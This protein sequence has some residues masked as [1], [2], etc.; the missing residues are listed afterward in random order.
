MA[1]RLKNGMPL[2][3]L[4][5][6]FCGIAFYGLNFGSQ[7]DEA[8]GK[9]DSIKNTV[10]TGIFLQGADPTG[11]DYS[12]GGVNYL[13]TW[14]G[15]TPEVVRW[16][17]KGNLSREG[18]FAEIM[19]VLYTI[20][21]R[22][23]VRAIYVILSSL[24][25]VWIF[26]L[27]VSLG[28]TRGEAF[29]AAA[30]LAGSWEIG[31]HSRFVAPDVVMM[32]FGLLAFLCLTRAFNSQGR[33]W[34]YLGAATIGLA[35]GTKYTGGLVLPFFLA[36]AAY[37]TWRNERSLRKVALHTVGVI[38]VSALIFLV[39]T[40][41]ALIDPFRFFGQ[42]KEQKE[43][44]ASGWY[45]Y[46]VKPGF[47][48]FWEIVKYFA[49]QM[50]SHYWSVSL[51]LAAF[52]LLGF[53]FLLW[54][55]TWIGFLL[56][57]FPL[58][59]MGYFSMQAAMIVR[60][61]LIVAP[62]LCIAAARGIVAVG[63]RLKSLPQRILYAGIALLLII[64]FGWQIYA[65][66]QV[67]KRLNPEYFL[68]QFIAYAQE[69]QSQNILA[70]PN[71][72]NVLQGRTELPPNILTDPAGRYDKVA[73]F[74][75]EGADA[76]WRDWPSNSWGLYEKTFG[77]LEVN[78]EAYSTFMGNQRILLVTAENFRKLPLAQVPTRNE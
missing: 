67:K 56:V 70:S 35:A 72:A 62:F 9:F 27:C 8:R 49:I 7:W 18:L 25:I 26:C 46:T 13:L 28:R 51:I 30:M 37:A 59:Y 76:F 71:L 78:L 33:L 77:P 10:A 29:L 4:L 1:N 15:L 75:S 17:R 23:R 57:A 58:A 19:P 69:T 31:Y 20:P 44:Y 55:F 50:L 73:F 61:L 60:N 54:E 11:A 52:C 24:S 53:F 43:V 3:L 40:P 47:S 63:R 41:A 2:L 68:R 65:A 32:Q 12:Y 45:G 74:Q 38:G 66:E 39:T 48:H 16:L 5:I 6:L 36:G 22:L 64:N 42:L 21:V 34:L 14:S